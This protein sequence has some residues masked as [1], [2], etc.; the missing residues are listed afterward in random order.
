MKLSDYESLLS[1]LRAS[2][3]SSA[4]TKDES[5]EILRV[6]YKLAS[7]SYNENDSEKA[8]KYYADALALGEK[9]HL[10]DTLE[11]ACVNNSLGSAYLKQ[12]ELDDALKHLQKASE[13]FKKHGENPEIKSQVV[14]NT[15]LQAMVYD[16]KNQYAKAV[17]LYEKAL[18]DSTGLDKKDA[19]RT[20]VIVYDRLGNIQ[21]I[22]K[23]PE[24]AEDSWKKGLEVALE[25]FGKD[26]R[27]AKMFYED[28]AWLYFS[29]QGKFKEAIEYAEKA[30]TASVKQYGA[31]GLGTIK[32]LYHLGTMHS[33]D[34]DPK[35]G[36]EYFDRMSG[37]LDKDTTDQ[38]EMRGHY[39]M[40][41]SRSYFGSGNQ[42]KAKEAFEK[43]VKAAAK[44][45]GEESVKVGEYYDSWGLLLKDNIL[46][47]PESK[48]AFTKAL[49]IFKKIDAKDQNRLVH[50][51]SALGEIAYYDDQFDE[52]LDMFNECLKI[53]QQGNNEDMEEVYSY[54]G[55]IY[56][57]KGNADQSVENH[58]KAIDICL[59]RDKTYPDL[60][61]HYRNLGEAY[62]KKGD[63]ANAKETY[64]K[65]LEFAAEKYGN[66]D[67]TTQRDLELVVGAL[68]KMNKSQEID[69]L[70]KKYQNKSA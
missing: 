21:R 20:L 40:I 19:A 9:A 42:Q 33:E 67:E 66:D 17:E 5:T 53:S 64:Q 7:T 51:Y 29:Q 4:L 60:D 15:Y 59:N 11:I 2:K 10:N 26:S 6:L 38:H 35:K 22:E 45:F 48:K 50:L 14:E 43:A 23:K 65:A 34:G 55:N 58:K 44:G 31:E 69:S 3:N 47:V 25:N 16:R 28:L 63:F 30:L 56:L 46:T 12:D 8:L 39:Y 37:V 41:V 49:D 18:K 52:A 54:L 70:R 68:Q 32:N 36:F 13:I 61:F 24:K 1:N 27:E 57:Q 62:D